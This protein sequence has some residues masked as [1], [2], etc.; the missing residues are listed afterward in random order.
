MHNISFQ[1]YLESEKRFSP[2]TVT[3][4]L[5]DL[6]Q[7]W[8]FV[9]SEYGELNLS[10]VNH[11]TIRSWVVDLIDNEGLSSNSVNRKL[12]SL[13]TYYRF[14][15]LAGITNINPMLKVVSPKS[16]KRLPEFVDQASMDKF[17]D[18]SYFSDDL[19]G[20]RDHFIIELFYQTGIRLSELLSIKVADLEI[21]KRF[22]E[23][24]REEE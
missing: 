21:G 11:K 16:S 14:L 17:L 20:R 10:D 15:Q 19:E 23:N 7:F 4:Y 3:A 9:H 12:S 6:K 5:K 2:H 13:K 8:A 1:K 24:N 18:S 22:C